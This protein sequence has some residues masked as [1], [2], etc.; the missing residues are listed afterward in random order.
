LT[1]AAVVSAAPAVAQEICGK[2]KSISRDR[3]QIV[4]R[5][6]KTESDVAQHLF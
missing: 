2:I 6:D 4:V 1:V 5:D 3:T